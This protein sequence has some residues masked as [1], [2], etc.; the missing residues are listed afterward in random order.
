ML[1]RNLDSI[2]AG[3]GIPE[4]RSRLNFESVSTAEKLPLSPIGGV[5]RRGGY[6]TGTAG[7]CLAGSPRR[8][9]LR[10]LRP[11][12]DARPV[13][14]RHLLGST[15]IIVSAKHGQWPIEKRAQ[16]DRRRQHH[17]MR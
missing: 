3:F 6:C 2:D 15:D 12:V 13:P 10:R 8:A 7:G 17:R 11:G 9:A 16:A 4:S 1:D 5:E 14:D